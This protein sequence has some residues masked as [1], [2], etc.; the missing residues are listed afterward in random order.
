MADLFEKRAA[1]AAP[2]ATNEARTR[3]AQNLA[4]ITAGTG[5]HEAP[6]G[7]N[8]FL[9]G[10]GVGLAAPEAAPAA[11][12]TPV[13]KS[14]SDRLAALPAPIRD[15]PNLPV[16]AKELLA[17]VAAKYAEGV[18]AVT[19][20]RKQAADHLG[21]SEPQLDVATDMLTSRGLLS[22]RTNAFGSNAGYVPSIPRA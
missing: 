6:R 19:F 15:L 4:S 10:Y 9:A 5:N 2:P 22:K 14:K 3:F 16:E 1:K 12:P 21:I 7:P 13:R 11:P 17:L 20:S 18:E 8:N